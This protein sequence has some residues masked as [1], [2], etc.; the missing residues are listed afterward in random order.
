MNDQRSLWAATLCLSV[1]FLLAACGTAATPTPSARPT[2]GQG[3]PGGPPEGA[4]AGIGTD[5]PFSLMVHCGVRNTYFDRRWWMANPILTDAGGLNLPADWTADDS[6]GSMQL[7][8][9]NHAKF[10]GQS[11]RVVEFTPWPSEIEMPICI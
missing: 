10:T 1:L 9:E 5:Y 7:V 8:S 11:G 6:R 2:I 3:V 4:G